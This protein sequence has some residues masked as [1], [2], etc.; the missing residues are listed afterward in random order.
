MLFTKTILQLKL[1]VLRIN[2][3]EIEDCTRDWTFKS[4]FADYIHLRWLV[5]S[6]KDW[7]ALFSESFRV[8]KPGGWVES[9]EASS[10]IKSDDNTVDKNSAMGQW[11]EFFI[12]GSKKIG[13]SFTV[14]EDG[15]QRKALEQA[16]FISI[17]EFDFKVKFRIFVISNCN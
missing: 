5:G 7:N 16:G 3:S 9:H 10:I 4:D 1:D 15:T 13:S 11:G 12:E 17:Q 14:V 2:L 8:C 6:I